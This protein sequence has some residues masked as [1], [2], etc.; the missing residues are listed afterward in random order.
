M[1]KRLSLV[2]VVALVLSLA[3][4]GCGGGKTTTP[5]PP[6][7][8]VEYIVVGSV[9][10]T[11]GGIATFGQSSVEGVELA[12]KQVNEAGGLLGGKQLKLINEDNQSKAEETPTAFQKLIQQD[13]VI[14]ILGSVASSHSLAGAPIA[15]AA[16]IP[17]ISPTSTNPKVTVEGGDFIFRACFIDPFQGLVMAKF[18][19]EE[20]GAKTAAMIVE[21]ESDYAKGLAEFFKEAF[22]AAGGTVLLEEF[23]SEKDTD[24]TPILT[25][26]KAANPDVVF[27]PSYYNTVGP[28]M[29]QAKEVVGIDATFL[30]GDGWD[31]EDL[32]KL[33]GD[34]ANG[35][36]FSNHYSPDVDSPQVK[37][38][39]AA[40]QAAYG[41][42][43]DALAALAYDAAWLL[44]EAIKAANSTTG[45]A[46]R[47]SLKGLS[48]TGVSG[49]IVFDENRNPIK[50]A[51]V[52]E[53]K[54]GKQVYKTT[55]NP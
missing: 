48:F 17:M 25:K 14:A 46:I 8:A 40:Y 34:A 55:V 50:S 45:T 6:K 31:S 30:G 44:I 47:D 29:K 5:E 42:T 2:L 35:G 12:F 52:I 36:F 22:V 21:N 13:K 41:K 53:I 23:F 3:L 15:Q 28:I 26:V 37:D 33:A 32:F 24:F 10:P 43:P 7:P 4:T 39:I 51:V 11:S 9:F 54:D 27:V 49:N 18:A 1:K 19:S 38:F 20:L 16:R